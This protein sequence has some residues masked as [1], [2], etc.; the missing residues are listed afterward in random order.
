MIAVLG[1]TGWPVYA[2]VIRAETYA[3]REREFVTAARALG[4]TDSRILLRELLPNVALR[5][6]SC[7]LMN[8]I[9]TSKQP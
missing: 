4:A 6:A 9:P 3:L 1:A 5:R 8:S 7:A 2:R